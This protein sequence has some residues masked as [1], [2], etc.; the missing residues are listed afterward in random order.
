MIFLD[1]F[2]F[3]FGESVSQEN[4]SHSF[5]YDFSKDFLLPISLALLAAFMAYRVFILETQKENKKKKKDEEERLQYFGLMINSVLNL[6]K[7][8]KDLLKNHIRQIHKNQVDFHPLSVVSTNDFKRIVETIKLDDYLIYY[9]NHYSKDVVAEFQSII[10]SID[11]LYLT[12]NQ[13][14]KRILVAEEFDYERKQKFS[15]KY[16]EAYPILVNKVFPFF[17]K[18]ENSNSQ[19]LKAIMDLY[20]KEY[21]KKKSN[22]DL[23]FYYNYFFLPISNFFGEFV[24]DPSNSFPPEINS[25][26]LLT[27]DGADLFNF[28]K[29]ENLGLKNEMVAYF[30]DIY[31]TIQILETSSAKIV[32]EFRS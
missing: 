11:Y 4:S 13:I 32:N 21:D 26:Y 25:F 1:I 29:S 28:I 18:N 30:K 22:Y 31:R 8:Q 16:S 12:F 20:A 27:K 3:I 14:S 10:A 24:S 17:S 15:S 19:K 2:R 7:I 5:C 6:S 9:A 23:E